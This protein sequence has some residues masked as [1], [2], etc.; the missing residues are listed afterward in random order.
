[1]TLSGLGNRDNPS[2]SWFCEPG[3]CVIVKLYRCNWIN[4]R[5]S[6]G[7]ADATDL[8]VIMTRGRWSLNSRPWNRC[9]PNTIDK[10]SRSIQAYRCSV[11]A[12]LLLAYAM[13]LHLVAGVQLQHISCLHNIA[14][15]PVYEDR[16]SVARS[17]LTL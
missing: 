3:R 17:C 9:I 13:G 16:S 8:L 10:S 7:G 1:M 14:G 15:R 4:I 6:L 11:G 2:A 5:C 12:K